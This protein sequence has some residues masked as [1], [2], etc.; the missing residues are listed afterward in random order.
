MA[1]Y[2]KEHIIRYVEGELPAEEQQRFEADML[3]DPSLAAEVSLY[4][5]LKA[6][7]R[8]RL[9]EDDTKRA[10]LGTLA[11]LN[12]TYFGPASETPV[13][14][15]PSTGAKRISMTRWLAGISAAAAVILVAVLLWPSAGDSYLNRLG[16]TNMISLTERGDGGDSLLQQAAVYFNKEE[17]TKAL[18]LLD[19]AVRADSAGQLALFYR[20]VALWHTGSADS[21]RKDLL[22]VYN[23]G[24]LLQY[25]AAFYIALSYAGQK[26]NTAAREWLRKIP[27]GAPISEKARDLA[28]KIQ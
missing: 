25:E 7:L 12:K 15:L 10:L 1:T 24:S 17:F 3:N 19:I 6:T 4:T 8:Q 14:T 5:E 22:E 9:P 20:G 21:A 28:R 23:K 18:P 13:R 2:D 11:E 26:N 16:R 27:E